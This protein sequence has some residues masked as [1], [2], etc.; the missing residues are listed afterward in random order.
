MWNNLF[1]EAHH[2]SPTLPGTATGLCTCLFS[3]SLEFLKDN[4]MK[5]EGLTTSDAYDA[6]RDP[7]LQA[8]CKGLP[9]AITLQHVML[10]RDVSASRNICLSLAFVRTW[11]ACAFNFLLCVFLW[12][13]VLHFVSK[14]SKSL[15]ISQLPIC[16]AQIA[17]KGFHFQ[18]I[19]GVYRPSIAYEFEHFTI[20]NRFTP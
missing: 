5:Q 14:P 19:Q 10:A 16:N 9:T 12:S 6:S 2:P 4:V 17:L 7:W 18:L 15:I 13:T 11:G 1:S 3:S 20:L 8:C